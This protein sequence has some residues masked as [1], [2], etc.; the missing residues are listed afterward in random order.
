MAMLMPDLVLALALEFERFGLSAVPY[1]R[2]E[3]TLDPDTVWHIPPDINV[4]PVH[5]PKR[6]IRAQDLSVLNSRR[7][8]NRGKANAPKAVRLRKTTSASR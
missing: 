2:T 6:K 5:P 8:G 7:A 4:T 1:A 3:P